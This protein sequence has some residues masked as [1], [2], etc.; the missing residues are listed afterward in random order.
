MLLL[1]LVAAAAASV[2]ATVA[3]FYVVPVV[4][5]AVAVGE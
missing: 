5:D 1:G 2:A 4:A 3:D